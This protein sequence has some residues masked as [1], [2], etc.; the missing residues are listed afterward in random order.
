MKIITLINGTLYT[1]NGFGATASNGLLI[2]IAPG[3][4]LLKDH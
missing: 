3:I 4:I 1:V 2:I